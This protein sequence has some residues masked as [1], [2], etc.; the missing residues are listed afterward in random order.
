MIALIIIGAFL[1]LLFTLLF[2]PVTVDLAFNGKL[3]LKIKYLG[4][5]LFDNSKK[6][7]AKKLKKKNIKNEN[8]SNAPQK[9]DNFIKKTYKEKG[10]IGTV[11]YF[12]EIF[13]IVAKRLWRV[14][15][16][17]K[18]RKFKVDIIVA[19]TDAANTA[20]QYGRI[21]AAVYP[22]IS[23]L[24]SVTNLKPKNINLSAD[25]DKTTSEFRTSIL[26]K[27]QVIYLLIAAVGILSQFLKLE[28]KERE[29]HERKQ[30]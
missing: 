12:S 21:C 23:F 13:A 25:F 3:L 16:R 29:K 15:K 7:T 27:T 20:I 10:L 2:L 9:K 4:I 24:Q 14:I 18:F 17:F 30:H 22:L 6:S 8:N 19:T 28:R 5:I 11:S 26:V 1:A